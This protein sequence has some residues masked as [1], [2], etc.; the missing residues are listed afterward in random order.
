[1]IQLALVISTFFLLSVALLAYRTFRA[2]REHV[3]WFYV[4][5]AFTLVACQHLAR[6]AAI[7]GGAPSHPLDLLFVSTGVV[8]SL[9]VFA[10]RKMMM[11][12][13]SSLVKAEEA[14]QESEARYQA[15]FERV[16]LGLYRTAPSGQ[17]VEANPALVQMLGFPDRETL[18]SINLADLYVDPGVR[19]ERLMRLDSEGI[20]YG[21]GFRLRRYDG[22]YIWVRDT[23]R[24]I[25]DDKG[26]VLYYEGALE[27]I[28]ERRQAEARQDMAYKI[29]EA[30]N[31]STSIEDLSRYI[32]QELAQNIDARNFY[33]AFCTADP[34]ILIFPYLADEKLS[35]LPLV[36]QRLWRVSDSI[37]GYALRSSRSVLLSEE[38]INRLTENGV[39][40][41]RSTI[42][43][44]WL[45]VPLRSESGIVGL[46]AVQSYEDVNAYSQ[47]DVAFL[48]FISSQIANAIQ[49]IRAQTLL[50]ESAEQYLATLNAM[51][52]AVHVADR[53]LRIVLANDACQR[54]CEELGLGSNLFGNTILENFPFLSERVHDEYRRVFQTGEILVTEDDTVVGGHE[55]TTETRKIPIV[56]GGEVVRVLTIIRDVTERK[57]AEKASQ[58]RVRHQSQL[59]EA[60]RHLTAS[61]DLKEVLTRLAASAK[62]MLRGYGCTIYLLE[63]D[64]VTLKA[65]VTLEPEYEQEILSATLHVD[66]SLTGQAV[67]ARRGMIF[68]DASLHE[69]AYQIPGTSFIQEERVIVVPLLVDDRVLGAICLNRIGMGFTEEELA[70][71]E[72]LAAYAST[73]LKNAQTHQDLQ[74]E[75]TERRQAEE[76]LRVERTYFQRLFVSAPEAIALLDVE[77]RVLRVN[78]EF[79]R[80]FGYS[81]DEVV[82]TLLRELIVPEDSREEALSAL[83]RAVAGEVVS[84]ES[85][86]QRKDGTP[87][88]VSILDTSFTL[89]DEQTG[90]Y[91]IYRD[92]SERKRAEAALQESEARFR[93]MFDS[94]HDF[95]AICDEDLKVIWA[96]RAWRDR[97]VY[98]LVTQSPL[99]HG[100][101]PEDLSRATEAWEAMQRGEGDITDQEYRFKSKGGDYIYTSWTLRRI[102]VAGRNYVYAVAHDIAARKAVEEIQKRL[103]QQERLAAVGQLAAGVAHDFNNLLTGIIGFAEMLQLDPELPAQM[104]PD[105]EAI[106]REG[107]RGARLVRQI[108]D[109]SR[110]S[111]FMPQPVDLRAFVK[112]MVDFWR[113]TIPELIRLSL[114][115]GTG[116]FV[117][118]GDLAQVGQMLT[119][120]VLNARDA[121]PTGGD[122]EIRLDRVEV[123]PGKQG[124]LPEMEA[125]KW[126]SIAIHD[127]GTGMTAEVLEH[128]YEPFFTTKEPGEGTGLGLAQ[129]YGIVKQHNGH[130][131]VETAVDRGTTFTIYLPALQEAKPQELSDPSLEVPVGRGEGIL[132]VEDEPVVLDTTKAMLSSLGYRIYEARNGAEAL[133]T[134]KCHRSEIALVISD[135]IMPGISG[136]DLLGKLRESGVSLPFILVSGYPLGVASEE[137]AVHKGVVWLG[138]PFSRGEMAQAIRRALGSKGQP[139][140]SR[141]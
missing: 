112:Q 69:A 40:K 58:D 136:T 63:P 120:L 116:E 92:I 11:T 48:E 33:L 111:L 49:R 77:G 123:Y 83:H 88:Y 27:D 12:R 113:R 91:A 35:D 85:V 118:N 110:Q 25:R 86:R 76:A 132:L 3:G 61:L 2:N 59:L 19:A 108:L 17:I 52:D 122:L 79:S 93:V 60:A 43:K 1:M 99:W 127:T 8:V 139:L 32:H 87:V 45:G 38:E 51:S 130:I 13:F 103:A 14:L 15:L 80:M 9:L 121:M 22:T 66:H 16:P 98:T 124:P 106:I 78:S 133:E 73:A 4:T 67:K 134:Y 115:V 138:K 20:L 24:A 39:V 135:V 126:V 56:E 82:G 114:R 42:P 74:H 97:L 23:A 95:M 37:T 107:Q 101:H 41:P 21:S 44:A 117:V 125:G 50:R 62:E 36:G 57:R 81:P 65:V 100:I 105:L 47:E 10:S 6:L 46:V 72:T 140:P 104:R 119:N 128:L 70:L 29:A 109:F 102:T 129:V 90:I 68:N 55:F 7:L 53:D 75:V 96:N 131:S 94:A 5:I 64:E 18:L 54:W 28:T 31:R 137:A 34:E 141:L 71:A 26:R 84:F 30:T 89:G